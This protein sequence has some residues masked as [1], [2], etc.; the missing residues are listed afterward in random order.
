MQRI[1]IFLVAMAAAGCD[2]NTVA[3]DTGRS[4]EDHARLEQFIQQVNSQ[5][6]FVEGGE[7]LMG[8]FGEQYGRDRLPFDSR[9]DSKPL[10][11]VALT[12]YSLSKFKASNQQYQF[13]LAW[14]GL[15]GRQIDRKYWTDRVSIPDTPARV[16]WGEAT[17]Y[18]TWLAKI[19]ELPFSLPTEAQWEYAARSRGQYFTA[20]TDDGTLRIEGRKGS[21]ISSEND[22][23]DYAKKMLNSMGVLAPLPG[24]FRPPNPLGIYDMAGNGWEWV[25]DW[26]DPDYYKRS[27]VKDPQGPD[28][29]VFKDLDGHYT[30]VLRGFNYSSAWGGL[31]MTRYNAD[32]HSNRHPPTDKTV[33]CAV[34]SPQP[35]K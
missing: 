14:N 5:L 26:Y 9:Q 6:I 2:Q 29:P 8:D 4:S 17:K 28:K 32:P 10:H 21:N 7:F 24:D 35:V 33:R 12:S 31:T 25:K 22:R 13:Y 15:Q 18:C 3:T 20:P 27:P 30:R 11:Q 16:D 34:N 19:T 23:E 1:C